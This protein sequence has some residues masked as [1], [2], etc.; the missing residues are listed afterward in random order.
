MLDLRQRN[1]RVMKRINGGQKAFFQAGLTGSIALMILALVVCGCSKARNTTAQVPPPSAD[2]N[3]VVTAQQP[4]Y[5]APAPGTPPGPGATPLVAPNGQPDLHALDRTLL[6]WVMR[7]RRRPANFED[8]A[9]TAGVAIP[10]PPTGQKY[11]I[12]PNMH[13]QLVSQ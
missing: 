4:V 3:P 1:V 11:I 13:I 5:T 12:A 6:R 2:T 10:A 7:N 8:F 9:A